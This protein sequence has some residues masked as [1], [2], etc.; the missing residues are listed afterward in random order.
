MVLTSKAWRL[1]HTFGQ[2]TFG[3]MRSVG[4]EG[5]SRL[6]KRLHGHE[7]MVLLRV[8]GCVPNSAD[9]SAAPFPLYRWEDWGM[10]R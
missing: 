6:S 9:A 4:M 7:K 8:R 3:L 2:L 1:Q 5:C 10:D